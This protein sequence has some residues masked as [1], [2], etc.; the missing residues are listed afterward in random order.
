VSSG[1]D[2]NGK[3]I[4]VERDVATWPEA[5]RLHAA[6]KK[7]AVNGGAV[8]PGR[9]TVSDL[10]GRWLDEIGERDRNDRLVHVAEKTLYDYASITRAHLIP[11]MGRVKLVNLKRRHVQ[12]LCSDL[13]ASGRAPRTIQKIVRTL[14]AAMTFAT[15]EGLISEN[16]TKYVSLPKL[17]KRQ[18]PL[19]GAQQA[20]R[21]LAV[22][23][24]TD[25][26]VAATLALA[27]GLREAECCGLRWSDCDLERG[28]LHVR[29]TAQ[30]IRHRGIQFSTPKSGQERAVPMTPPLPDVLLRA[31]KRQLERR[32]SLGAAWNDHDLVD[33]RGDGR[34]RSSEGLSAAWKRFADGHDLSGL[35]FHDL[36]HGCATLALAA[37]V[38]IK[39]V[40][41]WLGHSSTQITLDLYTHVLDELKDDMSVRLGR[42]L[43][44][45][46]TASDA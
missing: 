46:A 42:L 35:W 21:I 29:Q 27:A 23:T 26:E 39:V 13:L 4:R 25:L 34:P 14:S 18:P 38:P 43:V 30:T 10:L 28:I 31:R 37:G 12:Q 24:D 1:R 20:Q 15:K 19:I 11:S 44:A 33:D 16:P 6:L 40:S 17:V 3:R 32:V 41:E 5:V 9:M 7:Q 2:A 36:R 22:V 8:N 45:D